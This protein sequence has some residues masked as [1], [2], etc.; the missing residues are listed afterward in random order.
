MIGPLPPPLG[1]T[2]VLFKQLADELSYMPEMS[3]TLID[4]ALKNS[5]KFV[6]V[7]HAMRVLKMLLYALPRADAVS[8]HAST[9]GASRFGPIVW[10]ACRIFRRKWIFRGFGGDFD[11]WY[12]NTSWLGKLLFRRTVLDADIALFET[13][14]S[15]LHFKKISRHRVYWHPNSRPIDHSV[16]ERSSRR[17]SDP[18]RF[19]YVGHVNAAKGIR[20]LIAA[21]ERIQGNVDIDVYGPL[22][23]QITETAF[24]GKRTS[25]KGVL[26]PEKIS[27]A[28]QQYDLLVLPTYHNGEGH[29][30]VILEAYSAG[31]PVIATRWRSIPEIVDETCGVFVEP[32]NTDDLV[33]AMQMFVQSPE[34]IETLRPGA[35]K[36]ASAF[37]SLFWT[38]EFAMLHFD[39]ARTE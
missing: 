13:K 9:N 16:R 22:N 8:F 25:Y 30:G 5:G 29:P 6:G 11:L 31:L 18:V 34:K 15:V 14:A 2:T 1:G 26:P 23:D 3:V 19:L 36:K 28:M 4:T 24:I 12:R 39:L 38:G 27:P 21:G 32:G 37:S 17:P 33:R 7:L 35:I 20:E 10:A